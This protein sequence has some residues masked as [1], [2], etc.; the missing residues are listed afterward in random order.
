MSD[1]TGFHVGARVIIERRSFAGR[2]EH[3]REAI[4]DRETPTRWYIGDQWV[5]KGKRV[6]RPRYLD[7]TSYV[8]LA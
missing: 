8:R 7:T 6:L 5:P 1:D 4:I 2:I 3:A